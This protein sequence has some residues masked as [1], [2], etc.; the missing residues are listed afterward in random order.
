MGAL[1]GGKLFPDARQGAPGWLPYA[2]RVASGDQS[3]SD[4]ICAVALSALALGVGTR[5]AP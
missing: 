4:F 5:R 2:K 3:N 1:M